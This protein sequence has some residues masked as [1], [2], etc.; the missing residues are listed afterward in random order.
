MLACFYNAALWGMFLSVL[1]FQDTWLE[2]RVN[3]GLVFFALALV[4]FALQIFIRPLRRLCENT[5]ATSF[6]LIV[7]TTV[8]WLMLGTEGVKVIPAS[9]L[10]EGLGM[11]RLSF[12]LINFAMDTFVT[13]GWLLI[14]FLYRKRER[15]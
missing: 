12:S 14:E 13:L 5:I 6:S 8:L 10:R 7:V 1:L 11:P 15:S 3:L 2:M 4:L 9:I